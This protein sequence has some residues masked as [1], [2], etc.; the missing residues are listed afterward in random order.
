MSYSS[1]AELVA[2]FENPTG[3]PT[4]LN[5]Q[6]DATHTAG[7]LYQVTNSTWNG[8]GGYA[9]A[10]SAPVDVQ[11]AQ[12]AQMVGARGLADYTCPGCDPALTNYVNNNPSALSLPIFGSGSA[13]ASSGASSGTSSGAAPAGSAGTPGTSASSSSDCGSLFN[14]QNWGCHLIGSFVGRFL[15]GIVGLI[16]IIMALAIYALRTRDSG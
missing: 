9:S 16:L 1:L 6:Y 14:P 8:F 15:Y 3:N 5:G 11:N 7:G 2:A 12:F 13:G 4:L 10:V